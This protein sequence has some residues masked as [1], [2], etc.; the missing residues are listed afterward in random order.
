MV[1][2]WN[3]YDFWAYIHAYLIC[4]WSFLSIIAYEYILLFAYLSFA[5]FSYLN[6]Y[7]LHF[8]I[9]CTGQQICVY[10][11]NVYKTTQI[12]PMYHLIFIYIHTYLSSINPCFNVNADISLHINTKNQTTFS[13]I[14]NTIGSNKVHTFL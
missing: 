10:H 13:R 4:S 3:C 7:L 2:L 12:T 9:I 5:A 6:F 11:L 8:Y 1:S 14:R